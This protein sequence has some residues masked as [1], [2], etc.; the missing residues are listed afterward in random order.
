MNPLI[1]FH[2]KQKRAFE[3]KTLSMQISFLS[4]EL[5]LGHGD[6]ARKGGLIVDSHVS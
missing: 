5:F 4:V 2:K 6:H 3:V 1:S